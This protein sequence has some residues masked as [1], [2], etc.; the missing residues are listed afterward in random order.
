MAENK[1]IYEGRE[2]CKA[3]FD[4]LY[5]LDKTRRKL[6]ERRSL[7]VTT[8]SEHSL[9]DNKSLA[10]LEKFIDVTYPESIKALEEERAEILKKYKKKI[11]L[12]PKLLNM[13]SN[14]IICAIAIIIIIVSIINLKNA[15]F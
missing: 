15:G 13:I 3:D 2:V 12:S 11:T 7:A 4:A 6:D 14:I 9:K 5:E 10:L 8:L 1:L